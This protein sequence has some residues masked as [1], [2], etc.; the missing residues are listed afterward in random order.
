[1]IAVRTKKTRNRTRDRENPFFDF[2][3]TVN[4]CRCVRYVVVR[5]E[6]SSE[7]IESRANGDNSLRFRLERTPLL[8]A[9]VCRLLDL[10]PVLRL[11][12]GRC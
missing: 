1:M 11:A 9:R 7:A 4:D 12:C 5:D 8:S 3:S 2:V 6:V 10:F